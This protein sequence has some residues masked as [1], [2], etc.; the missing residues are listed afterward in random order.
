LE[1]LLR[2][3]GYGRTALNKGVS[4]DSTANIIARLPAVIAGGRGDFAIVY[5]GTNDLGSISTV[6][7]SP[8]PTTTT[9]P[10]ASCRETGYGV[11]GQITVGSEKAVI[12]SR[13]G[14]LLTLSAPLPSAPAAGTAVGIDTEANLVTIGRALQ[15]AGYR[16]IV[17]GGQHFWNLASGGDT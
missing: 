7:A 3:E 14:T 9:F 12:L 17:I 13:D 2:A 5:A 6:Q 10:V 1:D 4:G 16:K 8:P 11:G 15:A